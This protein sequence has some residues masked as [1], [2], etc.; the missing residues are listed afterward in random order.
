[1]VGGWS[2]GD[3]Q[4]CAYWTMLFQC[5]SSVSNSHKFYPVL[6]YLVFLLKS[7]CLWSHV[8]VT[9]SAFF[10][11][12]VLDLIIA[13]ES[14]KTWTRNQKTPERIQMLLFKKLITFKPISWFWALRVYCH[15]ANSLTVGSTHFGGCS[16]HRFMITEGTFYAVPPD[17]HK[18]QNHC[19]ISVLLYC[20]YSS[21]ESLG[22]SFFKTFATFSQRSCRSPVILIKVFTMLQPQQRGYCCGRC[23]FTPR[24]REGRI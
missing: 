23:L 24:K 20:V 5:P 7:P 10:K 1:M 8:I 17:A 11:S 14:L 3:S 9:I 2:R 15:I 18:V 22:S 13:D 16:Y 19:K 12:K 4:P 6:W 21:A